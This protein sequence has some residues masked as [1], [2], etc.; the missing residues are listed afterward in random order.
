MREVETELIPVQEALERFRGEIQET[1]SVSFQIMEIGG[2]HP[3]KGN[4]PF[5]DPYT[6]QESTEDFSNIGK[7]CIAVGYCADKIA[8]KLLEKKALTPEDFHTIVARALVHDV[9]RRL[10]ACERRTKQSFEEWEIHNEDD[11]ALH[12]LFENFSEED[13]PGKDMINYLG[14]AGR[15]TGHMSLKEFVT[16]DPEGK[17]ILKPDKTLVDIIVHVA[18]DMTAS[19]KPGVSEETKFVAIEERM[20]LGNFPERHPHLFRS[21]FGFDA[22][23]HPVLVDDVHDQLVI[24]GLKQV[25][26]YKEWQILVFTFCTDRL[27]NIIDPHSSSSS[28]EHIKKIVNSGLLT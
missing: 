21:G 10:V 19:P 4:E 18:D 9:M 22:D 8:E 3:D 15:E 17:P 2:I 27:S 24:Q 7:H 5:F 16:L 13:A 6:Q 14:V 11:V 28:R 23:N 26:S 25:K 1:H 20:R 12:E